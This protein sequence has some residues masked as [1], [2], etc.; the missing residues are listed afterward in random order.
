MSTTNADEKLLM[1]T[2]S[3]CVGFSHRLPFNCRRDRRSHLSLLER[4]ITTFFREETEH[5]NECNGGIRKP[6]WHSVGGNNVQNQSSSQPKW[7]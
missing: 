3:K 2:D 4:P 6:V 1:Y 5:E 7:R